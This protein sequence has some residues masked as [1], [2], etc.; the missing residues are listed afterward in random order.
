MQCMQPLHQER[1]PPRQQE[2]GAERHRRVQHVQDEIDKRMSAAAHAPSPKSLRTT[3]A[4]RM[5]RRYRETLKSPRSIISRDRRWI[6]ET[7]VARAPGC[8]PDALEWF[9]NATGCFRHPPKCGASAS[10]CHANAPGWMRNA[11]EWM[12]RALECP[13]NAPDRFRDPPGRPLK[14]LGCP[15]HPPRWIANASE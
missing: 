4:I 10:G 5:R 11:L 3:L 7:A 6:I 8:V 2:N 9:A 13:S 12:R 15:N 14:A 1:D